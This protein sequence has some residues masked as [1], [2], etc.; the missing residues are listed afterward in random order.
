VLRGQPDLE[1]QRL[2]VTLVVGS[3]REIVADRCIV[4]VG[5]DAWERDGIRQGW[6]VPE[7]RIRGQPD[8]GPSDGGFTIDVVRRQ[9]RGEAFGRA[10]HHF[11]AHGGRLAAV[12][13]IAVEFVL[14]VAVVLRVLCGEAKPKSV[15]D[16]PGQ[17]EPAD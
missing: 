16:G 7:Q 4:G 1:F 10:P 6:I 13:R 15:A 11:A 2:T 8:K 17:V 14:D 9:S 3:G 12:R 5:D